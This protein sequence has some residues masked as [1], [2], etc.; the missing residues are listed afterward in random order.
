MKNWLKKNIWYRAKLGGIKFIE[1]P[2]QT[3]GALIFSCM[4]LI[5]Q[6]LLLLIFSTTAYAQW[7]VEKQIEDKRKELLAVG[8]DTMVCYYRYANGSMPVVLD[9]ICNPY[10]IRYL[11]W[12]NGRQAFIQRFDNC[13]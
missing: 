5:Y 8:I 10:E 7:G 3:A 2:A 1:A 12:R 13:K 11:F 4:R 6:V 9:T